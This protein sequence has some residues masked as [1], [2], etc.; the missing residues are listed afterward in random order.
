M[1]ALTTLS[2]SLLALKLGGVTTMNYAL[3]L[4]PAALQFVYDVI[5]AYRAKRELD[6]IVEA[7]EKA[8]ENIKED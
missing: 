8:R 6:I 5:Q 1:R 3:I 2:V 7:I 4:L